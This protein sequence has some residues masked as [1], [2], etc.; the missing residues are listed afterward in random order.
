MDESEDA[1]W[2]SLSLMTFVR[3][4]AILPIDFQ[5]LLTGSSMDGENSEILD[6]VSGL[7]GRRAFLLTHGLWLQEM[8]KIM[9]KDLHPECRFVVGGFKVLLSSLLTSSTLS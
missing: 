6:D 7:M 2:A 8:W 1:L 9:L 3:I 5:E 4:Q